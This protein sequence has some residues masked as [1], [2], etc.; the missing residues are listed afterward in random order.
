MA[1]VRG[2]D[3]VDVAQAAVL[4]AAA[5]LRGNRAAAVA[6]ESSR[7]DVKIAGDAEAEALIL[8]RLRGESPFPVLA[9]ESGASR[10]PGADEPFW[11]VD[12]LDGSV[13]FSRGLPL[14]AVAVALWRGKVPLLGVVHDLFHGETYVGVP[15]EGAW[16]DGRPMAVSGTTCRGEGILATGFPAGGAHGEQAIT[17]VA[18]RA[19]SFRKVRLLGSATLS[20]TWLADGRVDAYA[21]D[22]IRLW[23]VA[24]GLA[25]V[26]GA[27]G[28][29]TMAPAGDGHRYIVA[30]DNG[31]LESEDAP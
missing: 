13:N 24:A 12:P 25:L 2:R 4:A 22:G 8:A 11:I 19:A 16:R 20:L 29:F 18:R 1:A 26:A 23:D 10:S 9:E 27:G 6:V 28:R 17:R 3:W 15:G 31:C 7:H 30:A 5:H 21:E 14:A